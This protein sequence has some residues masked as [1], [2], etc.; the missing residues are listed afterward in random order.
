[1]ITKIPTSQDCY[2]KWAPKKSGETSINLS[3]DI[4]HYIAPGLNPGD[5][6]RVEFTLYREDFVKAI[7]YIINVFPLYTSTSQSSTRV[8]FSQQNVELLQQ[9]VNSFF[10]VNEKANYIVNLKYR[11]DGRAYLNDLSYHGFNI[12]EFLVEYFTK[13]VFDTKGTATDI[14]LHIGPIG[15]DCNLLTSEER[16]EAF[17]DYIEKKKNGKTISNYKDAVSNPSRGKVI[18]SNMKRLGMEGMLYDYT[19]VSKVHQL[20][21][22]V[23]TDP[24]NAVWNQTCSASVSCYR[25]FLLSFETAPENIPQKSCTIQNETLP[26]QQI[27]YGA[28]GTGKSFGIDT[29][30]KGHTVIRT[31]FHPDSDYST[32]V[33]AYKPAM[34]KKTKKLSTNLSI[35]DLASKLSGYYNDPNMGNIEGLQKFVFEYCPYLNGEIM[36]VNVIQLLTLAGV[37][38]S[39]NVEVNK[40]LKFCRLLP[41]KEEGKI[42]Y[43]F[44]PQAFIQAYVEAWK[45]LSKPVFLVV[46]EINRGNCAQI[47]GDIFQLLDRDDNGYSSYRINPNE[48]IMLYLNEEFEKGIDAAADAEIK[49]G[50]K[51][52]LPPNLY[53]WATMNTSDQSLF[54]IDSAF[55]R[56]WDWK[57]VPIDPAKEMWTIEVNGQSYDWGSFLTNMNEEIGETTSSEDKKLGFYFCKAK[58]GKISADKFVSKVLF[59]V[60]NDVFKDYGFDKDFFKNNSKPMS[61]QSYYNT[62]GS[63]NE[64]MI[65]KLLDNLGVSVVTEDDKDD[66][67]SEASD[68]KGRIYYSLNG[69]GSYLMS[70]IWKPL[71]DLYIAKFQNETPEDIIKKWNA[72]LNLPSK[73]IVLDRNDGNRSYS[74]IEIECKGQIFYYH[75]HWRI[76]DFDKFIERIN[77]RDWGITIAKL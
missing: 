55:K 48:D 74:Y 42:V 36:S 30:T 24:D 21:L 15:S 34:E 59:Y 17:F 16:K 41:K 46:E 52:C 7:G 26:L 56:R 14:R 72:E 65:A 8:E 69:E 12:R 1:M 58:D 71:F 3:T 63:V 28:P 43:K 76:K 9:K 18:Y 60:Y 22:A 53:I 31:T 33:G 39:Y 38:T 66:E 20:Y 47:F 50:E 19:D 5:D 25:E 29:A 70:A 61:F 4:V 68:S 27:F 75:N 57:Y 45:D 10:T 67:D 73:T 49:S 6:R 13:I 51:M 37:S 35:S 40:Y 54:P 77:S 23:V 44:I 11:E 64:V 2:Y 32:F 62:D